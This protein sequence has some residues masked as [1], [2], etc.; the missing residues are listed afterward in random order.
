MKRAAIGLM[1]LAF[2]LMA[3]GC[4]EQTATGDS[5]TSRLEIPQTYEVAIAEEYDKLGDSGYQLLDDGKTEE[6]LVAFK[7]QAELIPAGKWGA[8]NVACAYGRT[9]QVD[10]GLAWLTKAVENGWSTPDH[11][12]SDGDLESLRADARFAPLVE[13]AKE[14]KRIRYAAFANGLPEYDKAPQQFASVEEL[15]IWVEEQSSILSRNRAIWQD[16]Q[17]TA[18]RMDMTAKKLAALRELSKDD[19]EFDYGLER[20]RG[21]GRLQSIYN[22]WGPLAKGVV[23]E[24]DTYLATSPGP[25]GASEAHYRIGIASLCEIGA[26]SHEDAGWAT[27]ERVARTHFSQVQTGTKYEGSAQAWQIHCDLIAAKDDRESV[28]PT[29][30]TFTG[31]FRTDEPA[32]G[33][34]GA[35]FQEEVVASLWPIPVDA[36]DI[37]GKDVSLAQ[38]KGKVVLV[39]FWA[40]WCGPCR[41]ELP[42]VLAAYDKYKKQ[43]FEILSISLD[44]ADRT[45]QDEY[46]TWIEEKGMDKWRHVYDEKAWDGPLVDAYLVRGIPNPVMIGRDGSLAGMGEACRGDKLEKTIEE[47]LAKKPA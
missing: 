30:R 3:S 4:A 29:I 9:G 44:Y 13:Q 36:V 2:A 43:G 27:A 20:L 33:I 45:S 6:A 11:L 26:M 24:A 14:N 7:K 34:A 12:E 32:M 42:H 19:T 38:Y 23:K 21:I 40:T 15:D 46:R 17:Y 31:K 47:A 5:Q 41:A 25:E 16:W 8:Y 18:A 39:D 37:D 22:T 35:F 10:D 28:A 1:V